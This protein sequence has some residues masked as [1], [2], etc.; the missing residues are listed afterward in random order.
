MAACDR[1]R[2]TC[3]SPSAPPP[4][5]EPAA[6]EPRPLSNLQPRLWQTQLI[7]LLRRRW[8]HAKAAMS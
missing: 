2:L 1:C 7:Q 3:A 4:A 5:A 6:V 8:K